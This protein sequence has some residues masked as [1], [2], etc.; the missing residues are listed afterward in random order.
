M[1]DVWRMYNPQ[2]KQFSWYRLNPEPQF[3]RLDMF[4]VGREQWAFIDTCKLL[5]GFRTDHSLLLMNISVNEEKKGPGTWKLNNT[6]LNDEQYNESMRE[7]IQKVIKDY[8]THPVDMKWELIKDDAI[9]ASREYAKEKSRNHNLQIKELCQALE[10]L[11]LQLQKEEVE[12]NPYN[13]TA[14]AINDVEG[15]LGKEMA[16]KAKDPRYHCLD[17]SASGIEKENVVLRIFL[18]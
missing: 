7:S 4:F 17:P 8:A 9:Q 2:T 10:E 15:T 11:K 13:K 6:L 5:P 18:H 12:E 3:S 14:Q 1:C 16:F